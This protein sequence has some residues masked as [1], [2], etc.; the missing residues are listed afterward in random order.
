MQP[1]QG[2]IGQSILSPVG[3]GFTILMCVLFLV[4]PRKY[5]LLPVI[6]LTCYMSLGER[7]V[8]AGLNLTMLRILTLVGWMRILARGEIKSIKLNSIDKVLIWWASSLM[9]AYVMLWQSYDGFKYISGAVYNAIGMY[10]LFRALLQSSEDVIRVFRFTSLLIVPL[11][12]FMI[13]E[14]MTGV[15]PF[16][17][18]GGVPQISQVR[19]GVVRCQGPFAHPILAGTFGATLLPYF[20]ALWWQHGRDRFLCILGVCSS[21]SIT[22]LAGSSGPIA[23]LVAGIAALL[24][25][26]F[27]ESMQK[28][29]W[30]IVLALLAL[31]AVMETHVWW[32]FGRV[33]VF[34]GSDG[35]H[36][37]FLID[38][39]IFN[40]FDWWLVGTKSTESWGFSLWDIT[41]QYIFEGTRGGIL[42]ML[43]FIT[44]IV[45]CFRAVGR[46][47]RAAETQYL[48]SVYLSI[49]ALGAALIAH[50]VTFFSVS[51]FDQNLVNW[52][53]LLAM[54]ST[55]AGQFLDAK[56]QIPH[57]Q[58]DISYSDDKGIPVLGPLASKL[59]GVSST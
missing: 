37:S 41:N 12:V 58:V 17:L 16:A 48:P 43:L 31:E 20:V 54:I 44:I 49:W 8:I 5:A 21:I 39:A 11:V 38:R 40:F 36:R 6:M 52:F 29:R 27:R 15:N 3:M 47:V 4:L 55:A 56:L 59:S 53:L 30:G 45:R 25:W 7:I 26:R 2:P 42:T 10:F 18:F 46:S 24:I 1:D 23:A 14:K 28:V 57:R 9:I 50:V 32:I 13:L 33:S 19:L 51:Y 35:W 22:L 34:A